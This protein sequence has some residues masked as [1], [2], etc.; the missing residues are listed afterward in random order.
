LNLSWL[1]PVPRRHK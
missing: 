1:C